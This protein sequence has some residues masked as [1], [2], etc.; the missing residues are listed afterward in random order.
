MTFS[1]DNDKF[2]LRKYRVRLNILT[3][4]I[5]TGSDACKFVLTLYEQE[6]KIR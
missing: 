4:W 5:Q 6:P 1:H 3:K 2:H